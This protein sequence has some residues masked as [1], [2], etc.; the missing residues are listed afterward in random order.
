MPMRI[1]R[2]FPDQGRVTVDLSLRTWSEVESSLAQ[3]NILP[4][5][6]YSPDCRAQEKGKSYFSFVKISQ[7]S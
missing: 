3:L 5:G 6:N 4:G 1:K 2:S 7:E